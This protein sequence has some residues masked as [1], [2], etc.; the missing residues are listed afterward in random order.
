MSGASSV[1]RQWSIQ[2]PDYWSDRGTPLLYAPLNKNKNYRDTT[3]FDFSN[4]VKYCIV[5]E[6]HAKK[7]YFG[8]WEAFF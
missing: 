1:F 5:N 7:N 6:N 3:S 4:Y 8:A 2:K